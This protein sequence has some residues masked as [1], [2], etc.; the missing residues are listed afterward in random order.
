MDPSWIEFQAEN[1]YI[2]IVPNFTARTL[3]LLQCD[4]GPFKA[5]IP[6]SVSTTYVHPNMKNKQ[7]GIIDR[8]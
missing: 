6:L 1:G 8:H 4:A 7:R 2:D 5:G 3:S